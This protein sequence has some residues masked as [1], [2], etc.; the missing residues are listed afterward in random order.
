MLTTRNFIFAALTLLLISFTGHSQPP[1]EKGLST[2]TINSIQGPLTFLS[3]DHLNGREPGMNGGYVAAD[4]IASLFRT[5]GLPPGGDDGSYYQPVDILVTDNNNAKHTIYIVSE[6]SSGKSSVEFDQNIDLLGPPVFHSLN[7]E[8]SIVYAGYGMADKKFNE[9]SGIK[10]KGAVLVRLKGYPGEKDSLSKAFKYFSDKDKKALAKQNEEAAKALSVSAILEYDPEDPYLEKHIA[11]RNNNVTKADNC[12][13]KHN[14]HSSDIYTKNFRLQD[15]NSENIPVYSI[16]RNL[17]EIVFPDWGKMTASTIKNGAKFQ[18][19]S[20]VVSEK[21]IRIEARADVKHISTDNILAVIK[22][23]EKPG[24][25]IVVGAHY[26]HLGAYNGFIWNGADDNGSGAIGMVGIARAFA[27]TG[28]KPKRTVIFAAWT[29][30]ERGLLGSK[31]FVKTYPNLKN[32]ICYHNYDMIG[33]SYDPAKPDSAVALLYTKSWK[34]AETL[35][36]EAVE[37]Y[38]IGLKINYSA[39]DNPTSGSDNAPFAKKDIPIMW[40]HTGGHPDYHKPSDHVD[41]I[42]WQKMRDIIK[43]SFVSLWELANE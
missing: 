34:A 38:N 5:F 10:S 20:P 23:S 4:Y 11:K 36:K 2:I 37:K 28:V 18:A 42:D 9:L 22:G 30:E 33:R 29:A 15:D 26:D 43:V 39:W 32:I 24:E 16:S 41:H 8:G 14:T 40:F 21:K 17:L 19:T 12:E 1:V 7:I 35:T 6:N 13:V 25:V 31:Y 3:S 27:A